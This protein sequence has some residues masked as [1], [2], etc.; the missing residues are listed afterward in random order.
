[1]LAATQTPKISSRLCTR[2]RPGIL[3]WNAS[4]KAEKIT[5]ATKKYAQKKGCAGPIR[6][7]GYVD[8]ERVF[9]AVRTATPPRK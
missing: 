3:S 6:G 9:I 2:I 4:S 1:M 5:A 8:S 7:R